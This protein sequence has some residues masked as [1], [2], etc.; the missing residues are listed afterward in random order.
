MKQKLR[1]QVKA[2]ILD[3]DGVLWKE[4]E[5]IGNLPQIFSRIQELG[6]DYILATNNATKTQQKYVEKLTGFGAHIPE[7]KIVSEITATA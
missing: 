4:S 2:L 7:E 6:L 3:M 1:E 5:A